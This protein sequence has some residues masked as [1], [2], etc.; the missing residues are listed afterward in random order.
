MSNCG[1]KRLRRAKSTLAGF[2]IEL[3]SNQVSYS[4]LDRRQRSMASSTPVGN[5]T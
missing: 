4:L 1:A 5:L 2:G 3:V